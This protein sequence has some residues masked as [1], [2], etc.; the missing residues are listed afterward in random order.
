MK[1]LSI[2]LSTIALAL[3]S[4]E[5]A[6]YEG[7][8]K[9]YYEKPEATQ[10]SAKFFM[11]L[12][13][14]PPPGM[15]P[16]KLKE[17]MF[18]TPANSE[19]IFG[20]DYSAMNK[21]INLNSRFMENLPIQDNQMDNVVLKAE[22]GVQVRPGMAVLMP[23][24]MKY[25]IYRDDQV[26][27]TKNDIHFSHMEENSSVH[28]VEQ[29][30]GIKSLPRNGKTMQSVIS[31]QIPVQN[32]VNHIDNLSMMTV[33][34]PVEN[35]VNHQD[36]LLMK[37]VQIPVE[38][39]VNNQDNLSMMT[40]QIPVENIVN[41]QDNL[42]IKSVQVPNTNI[43]NVQDNSPMKSEQIPVE[44]VV[45]NQDNL[46]MMTVQLPVENIVNRQD[47]LSMKKEQIPVANIINVQDNLPM[48]Q[49]PVE[50]VVNH[51]DNLSIS[52]EESNVESSLKNEN[53]LDQDIKQMDKFVSTTQSS[54]ENYETAASDKTEK[55]YANVAPAKYSYE[56]IVNEGGN[57]FG[58]KESRDGSETQGEYYVLLP[59]CRKMTVTYT[60][61]ENGYVPEVSYKLM[62]NCVVQE[63][64]KAIS[65]DNREKFVKASNKL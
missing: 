63:P 46:S 33:Q 1:V 17:N 22:N 6:N 58:A 55:I 14:L 65:S 45:S 27:K 5:S 53:S 15:I 38:S 62:P 16:S 59:D 54:A 41:R 8:E 61:N 48:K 21:R 12:A 40:V 19:D 2:F 13:Y 28:S 9:Y 50:N 42:S 34:I 23:S 39:V 3:A 52:N 47:N 30:S 51:Q 10:E 32:H 35:I 11:P 25:D 4:L 49:I 37:S 31:V 20:R 24:R 56:Y 43:I 57:D 36:N 18:E 26:M 7:F 44:S 60:A 64:M 29:T